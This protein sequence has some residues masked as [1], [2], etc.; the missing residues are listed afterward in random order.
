VEGGGRGSILI[1]KGRDVSVLC[2]DSV[3]T[4]Q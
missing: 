1:L 4:A 2:K 3:R